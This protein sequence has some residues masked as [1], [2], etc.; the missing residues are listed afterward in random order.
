MARE[1]VTN[2][3]F[4]EGRPGGMPDGWTARGPRE[5][6]APRFRLTTRDGERVLRGSG[7]GRVDCVGHAVSPVILERGR[8]YRMRASFSVS[9]GLDPHRSLLFGVYAKDFNDG[10][11]RFTGTRDGCL[12]GDSRFAVPGSGSL[13][14]EVR[15]TFRASARGSAWIRSVS[16]E[17]CPPVP[18]R[19]VRVACTQ[20]QG[21]IGE[22]GAVLDAAAAERAE[23]V[24]LP[25][26]MNGSSREDFSG[27]SSTLMR[28]KAR[29]HGMYVAGGIYF[30]DKRADRLLN[31]VPLFDRAGELVGSYDKVHPYSPEILEQGVTPGERVPVFRTDFGLVGILICYD[32]WFTDVAE[33]LALRGAE[34][35]LFPNA[36]YY[37]SL[38]PARAA[39]NRARFVVSSLEGP[40][41]IWDTAG[42]DVQAP[43][44]DPTC[45]ANQDGTFLEVRERAVGRIRVLAATFDLSRSPSPHN[46]GGP[47]LSAPGGKRNRRDQLRPLYRDIAEELSRP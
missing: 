29:E 12:E 19:L 6:L 17:P 45:C 8:T 1:L 31:R 46:W 13:A 41:G 5:S 23:L 9:R 27:P 11:F 34:V 14:A 37:R 47:M 33:L 44:A 43:E 20:G 38:M 7:N 40:A 2:H 42:R 21:T 10:I 24:L 25:E 26:M 28:S 18:P 35:I 22:W 15:V 3:A 4:R 36:G 32:S 16:L 39:D 30:Y